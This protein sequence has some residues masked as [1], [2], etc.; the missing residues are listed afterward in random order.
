M[1]APQHQKD[2]RTANCA[3]VTVS[4]T[5][6]EE[7]DTGG[8]LVRTLLEA[9]GHSVQSHAIVKDEPADVAKLVHAMSCDVGCHAIL[10]SGGTG[11]AARDTTVEAIEPML[12]KRLDGF[13]ELFRMLSFDQ[14][15]AAS[16]LSR[17]LA[18]ITNQTAVFMM[19]G[20]PKAVELAMTKLIIPELGHIVALAGKIENK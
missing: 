11:I 10:L 5:R 16:M 3:I 18:G 9:A 19:P 4:D 14:V 17:A 8:Q 15:G 12:D 2:Q 6:T 7:T 13:G 1:P 20:S